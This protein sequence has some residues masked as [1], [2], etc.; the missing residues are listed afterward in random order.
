MKIKICVTILI[1]ILA[2]VFQ[3]FAYPDK[4]ITKKIS[5]DSVN[6]NINIKNQ[7]PKLDPNVYKSL[8]ELLQQNIDLNTS[9][10]KV[11]DKLLNINL[12]SK[13]KNE[14]T[15]FDYYCVDRGFSKEE[16]Q[17]KARSSTT[18]K[19]LS[20][21]ILIAISII[22]IYLLIIK[23]IAKEVDWKYTLILGLL[24]IVLI[25]LLNAKVEYIINYL[26]N[27]DYLI[28]KELNQFK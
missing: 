8:Q 16:V 10:Q 6:V 25:F 4:D 27:R 20:C 2:T 22:F 28:F 18:I 7:A 14:L 15:A 3:S 19:F 1:L 23:S 12:Q 11:Y 9:K 21:I 13:D 24:L 17:E 5:G 26:F